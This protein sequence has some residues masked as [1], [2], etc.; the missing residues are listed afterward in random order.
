[1]A[2]AAPARQWGLMLNIQNAVK[3]PEAWHAER[4]NSGLPSSIPVCVAVL[5]QPLLNIAD[6]E[7]LPF[8]A[9]LARFD[10]VIIPTHHSLSA[11]RRLASR[12]RSN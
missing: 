7:N 1:M 2:A 9:T 4:M 12:D 3:T 10:S 5:R 6:G 8:G 11:I